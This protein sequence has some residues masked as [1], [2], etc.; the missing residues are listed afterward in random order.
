VHLL[1][2]HPSLHERVSAV[3]ARRLKAATHAAAVGRTRPAEI[4]ALEGWRANRD[5][6]ALVHAVAAATEAELGRPVSVVTVATPGGVSAIALRRD[7][8]DG[9]VIG[10]ARDAGA[11]RERLAAEVALRSQHASVV[12]IEVDA[13][14]ATLEPEL[15]RLAD[16]VLLR[17]D[18]RPRARLDG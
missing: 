6:R 4:V 15:A 16:T 17:I 11:L 8:P 13:E 14:L 9:V 3:L 12:L 1:E 18:G 5:R 7:R 2:L 10:D